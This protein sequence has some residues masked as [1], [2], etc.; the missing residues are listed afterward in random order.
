MLNELNALQNNGTWELV[1]LPS[2]KSIVG[3]RWVFAI[4]VGPDGTIDCL[5]TRLVAKGYTQIFGLDYGDTFSPVAK[6]T[7]VRLFIAMTALQRW[8]LYQ[9]D[10]KNAFLNGDLQKK[11]IWSNLQVFLLRGSLL[12]W[13]V[14]FAN[15]YMVSNSL[16][17]PGLESLVVLLKNLV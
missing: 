10:V 8:P 3:C 4:K 12:D 16:P 5:K 1:S 14:V 13:Y 9:L 7:F 17:G 2:G 11:F 15:L 6:M